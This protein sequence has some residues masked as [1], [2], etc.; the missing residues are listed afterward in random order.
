MTLAA[1]AA[2]ASVMTAAEYPFAA[3]A[4]AVSSLVA[5]SLAALCTHVW[6]RLRE[7]AAAEE[8]EE[9]RRFRAACRKHTGQDNPWE[10]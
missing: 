5:L 9:A 6:G 8:A 10:L 4:A 3:V 1:A 2:A 7:L